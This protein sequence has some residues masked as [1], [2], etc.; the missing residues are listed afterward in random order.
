M[1]SWS[2]CDDNDNLIKLVLDEKKKATTS[3]YDK[4]DLP[5]IGEES[6]ILYNSGKPACII[7]TIDYKLLKFGDIDE[8]LSNLEGEGDYTKW[9]L[10]NERIFKKYDSTFNDETLVVFERFKVIKKYKM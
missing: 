9:K 4:N 5:L 3:N 6:I 10:N 8:S 7:K 2:F 1:K